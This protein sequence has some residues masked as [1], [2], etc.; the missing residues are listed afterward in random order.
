MTARRPRGT[1]DPIAL[2]HALEVHQTELEAQNAEL[3][4][5][6]VALVASNGALVIAR[7]RFRALY[8]WAPIPYVTIDAARTIVDLNHA[9]TLIAGVPR[10]QLLGRAVEE[11]V[12]EAD[13]ARFG[14]FV[15]AVFAGGPVRADDVAVRRVG[16]DPVDVQID[17]VVVRDP[18]GGA[19][20]CV[21]AFV[22]VTARRLAESARRVAQEEVLAVVSHDLRGPINA[23][24]LAC[25]ALAS[26]L[27]PEAERGYVAAIE[28]SAA[29]CERL[30]RDL[31]GRAQIEHGALDLQVATFDLRELV[32]QACADHAPAVAAAGSTLALALAPT[33]RMV[34]GDRDRLHQVVSN[35]IGN[36]LIHARGAALA[37]AVG[38]DAATVELI[39]SDA[40]PGIAPDDLPRVFE[41]FRQGRRRRGGTGLG[42]AIVKGL[43][44]AHQGT[45]EVD[46]ELGHGA[47]FVVRLPSAGPDELTRA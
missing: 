19:Q 30:I 39:V 16:G 33:P 22:D 37:V 43:V 9:A 35:L 31:L 18:A 25:E 1:P 10:D 26:H 24:G 5:A 7:D 4:A 8:E 42:L 11:L 36:A 45:V 32:R 47:R 21:L 17:G 46:S 20:H 29:R 12:I 27:G 6:N 41:W 28:R 14:G 13:R 44:L 23:I 38:G 15:D 3:A 2:L 40:G 34:I